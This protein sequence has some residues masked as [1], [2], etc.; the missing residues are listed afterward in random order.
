LA[1]STP[2]AALEKYRRRPIPDQRPMLAKVRG[3][4]T[5]K[6]DLSDPRSNELLLEA[7]DYG[8]VG[9]S[10]YA[11]A[12]NA[13]Y[14]AAVPGATSQIRLRRGVIERLS[15]VNAALATAD[16]E[17]FVF[18]GW[19]PRAVQ[20][21]F[22]DTWMPRQLLKRNPKLTRE[23]LRAETEKYWA[24]PTIDPKSPA[25]HATGG[26]VDLTIR[27]KDTCEHL[28]MGSIFDDASPVA[29][30][31]HFERRASPGLAFSD[32]EA[33]ANRRLLHWLMHNAG[34]APNP[35]EWWHFSYGE[36]MWAKLT[37]APHAFYGLIER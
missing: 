29:R 15:S 7:A 34:F 4:R 9:V 20:K 37:D 33:R 24:A 27:W 12:R 18:D 17:L 21:Y 19:R 5:Y 22:H 3:Y 35:G 10:H 2:F 28:W 6:L 30:A 23:E 32:E 16:L 31:D 11:T 26:A 36:L 13:P 25:P 14:Y 1:K 8:I